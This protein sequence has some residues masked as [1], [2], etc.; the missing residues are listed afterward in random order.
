MTIDE[1]CRPRKKIWVACVALPMMYV[2]SI[3]P[4]LSAL[5]YLD[6]RDF[7][8]YESETQLWDAWRTFY[9]PL[10]CVS[11]RSEWFSQAM[12]WYVYSFCGLF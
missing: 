9:V 10:D 11:E 1:P 4:T 5:D 2:L 8:S 7:L 6:K 3:A 12:E